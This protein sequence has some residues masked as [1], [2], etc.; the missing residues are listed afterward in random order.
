MKPCKHFC[1]RRLCCSLADMQADLFENSHKREWLLE[2]NSRL[3]LY[4]DVLE[5]T[6]TNNYFT[7]LTNN[8]D[9]QQSEIKIAGRMIKIPRLNAW[10]GDANARYQ[11]SG[12]WFDPLPWLAEL[13]EIREQIQHL[14]ENDFNSVLANLYRDG[15]DSVAWHAD[16]EPQLGRNPAIASLTLGDTR[17]FQLKH[18]RD[19]SIPRIDIDLPDNSLLVMD[20]ELQHHWIHK[21]PKTRKTVEPRINLTFRRVLP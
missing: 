14:T 2:N 21:V 11:Y 18:K 1:P 7:A 20:G 17:R 12:K 5:K 13:L 4:F 9:W 8:I 10:Y 6:A 16:D 3:V 15:Q 19:K